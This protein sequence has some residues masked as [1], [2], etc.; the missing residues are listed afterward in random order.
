MKYS[1][2]HIR[3]V[4]K[5][6]P[7]TVWT[8]TGGDVGEGTGNAVELILYGDKGHSQPVVIGAEKDF[9]FNKGQSDAFKVCSS[10][11]CMYISSW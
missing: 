5:G 3:N 8:E 2:Y 10:L 4:F 7:W 1:L 6:S 11:M 9:R